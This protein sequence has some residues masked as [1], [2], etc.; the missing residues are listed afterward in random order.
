MP[1]RADQDAA[2]SRAEEEARLQRSAKW[3]E[4]ER[5]YSKWLTARAAVANPDFP[6]D[7][8]SGDERVDRR[9]AVARALLMMPAVVPSMIWRKWEVLDGWV[10]DGDSPDWADNRI[11]MALGIIKADVIS[12]GLQE[13]D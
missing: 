2:A 8:A 4:F 9:D 12:L 13:P 10:S 5:L 11:T 3:K 7:D 1:N 6:E